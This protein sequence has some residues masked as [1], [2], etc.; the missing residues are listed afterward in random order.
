MYNQTNYVS[1]I[2]L[3]L[4]V[5]SKSHPFSNNLIF[6]PLLPSLRRNLD[7]QNSNP[8]RQIRKHKNLTKIHD[9][10]PS[11]RKTKQEHLKLQG[12]VCQFHKI[13]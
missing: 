7:L 1:A 10:K 13:D 5:D 4:R 3:H 2:Y 8:L 9:C 6:L 12:H 11:S